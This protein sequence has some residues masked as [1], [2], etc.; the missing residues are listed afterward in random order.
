MLAR[1]LKK[2]GIP[3][4]YY[5]SPQLWAWRAGRMK[6]MRRLADKV[7][8]IFPFEEPIYREAGV[9][10]E[11]VG[12]P[13]FDV[14]PEREPRGCVPGAA[15]AS[16]RRGRSSRCSRGAGRTSSARSFPVSRRQRPWS[17]RRVP[18][19]QLVLARAPHLKD[20]LLQ[21]IAAR[22]TAS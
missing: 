14:Q 6:T 21:P 8:V 11:W 12:H 19:V 13:L 2:R 22:W 16:I 7:L 4:V 15:P 18:G 17:G 1:A 5:I 9:P 3:I 10:V 20:E